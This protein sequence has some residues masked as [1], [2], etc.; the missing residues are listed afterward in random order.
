[1]REKGTDW[2]FRCCT[3]LCGLGRPVWILVRSFGARRLGIYIENIDVGCLH[4]RR[5]KGS[6]IL[7]GVQQVGTCGL[8]RFRLFWRGSTRLRALRGFFTLIDEGCFG[9]SLRLL[10]NRSTHLRL[11]QLQNSCE[12]LGGDL[13]YVFLLFLSPIITNRGP[14]PQ[15]RRCENCHTQI[16]TEL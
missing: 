8:A 15:A 5:S 4:D 1:M 16:I 10:H 6:M 3:Q 14:N 12:D 13:L 9:L 7:G 11:L 2:T